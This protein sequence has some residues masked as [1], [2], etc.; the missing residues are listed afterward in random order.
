MLQVSDYFKQFRDSDE[1]TE[2]V[3]KNAKILIAKVSHLLSMIPYDG[4]ILVTSGFRPK[5]YNKRIGG[6]PNSLHCFGAAIDLA[7]PD[8]TIGKWCQNNISYLREHGLYIESPCVT[9]KSEK[10][11]GKW[12]HIQNKPPKSGAIIFLP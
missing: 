12:C 7:D 8:E 5:S 4:P 3:E 6:S 9:H 1:I 10:P 11:S 2:E